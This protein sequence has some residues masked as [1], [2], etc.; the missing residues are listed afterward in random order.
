MMVK[1]KLVLVGTAMLHALV[2][3][4]YAPAEPKNPEVDGGARDLQARV[5][6][7][8]KQ[9]AELRQ[10]IQDDKLVN[11]LSGRWMEESWIRSGKRIDESKEVFGGGGGGAGGPVKWLLATDTSSRRIVLSPE[12]VS[13]FFGRFRVDTSKTPAWIDLQLFVE[14]DAKYYPVRGIV[15]YKYQRAEIAIPTRLF[16]GDKFLDPPRPTSFKSTEENGYSVY[17]LIRES[18]KRTGIW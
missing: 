15:R 13:T 6:K 7:L 11:K 12:P 14:R 8:E 5:A 4:A 3:S 18:F 10:Q 16:D 2:L 9:V 1:G 17:S